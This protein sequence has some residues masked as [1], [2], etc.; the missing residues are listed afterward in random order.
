MS[1]KFSIVKTLDESKLREELYIYMNEQQEEPYIFLNRETITELKSKYINL[2]CP[3]IYRNIYRN[4]VIGTYQGFK[5]YENNDL[6]Y[7]EVELR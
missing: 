4:G 3:L 1:K 6:K 5:V 2:P 7:G